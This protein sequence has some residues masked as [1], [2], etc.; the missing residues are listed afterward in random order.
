MMKIPSCIIDINECQCDCH[1]NSDIVHMM[2]CCQTCPVCGQGRIVFMRNHERCHASS[3][4][5]KD[6]EV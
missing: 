6:L 4:Y 2:P 1:Y 3:D 5:S